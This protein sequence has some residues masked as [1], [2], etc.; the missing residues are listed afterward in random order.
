MKQLFIV[1]VLG[2][3]VMGCAKR[4]TVMSGQQSNP[5]ATVNTQSKSMQKA[6]VAEWKSVPELEVVYFG[7]KNHGVGP[8]GKAILKKNSEFLKSNPD[9]DIL[10]EVHCDNQ[11]DIE[12]NKTLGQERADSVK[13]YYGE[14]GIPLNK[15]TTTVIVDTQENIGGWKLNRRAETKI[16]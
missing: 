2:V 3:L 16:K 13:N 5:A 6:A 7:F 12:H 10:V 11:G 14:L 1:L 8:K 9:K 15:I 4:Q